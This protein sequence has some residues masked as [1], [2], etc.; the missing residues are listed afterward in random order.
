[1]NT[2]KSTKPAVKPARRYFHKLITR[3]VAGLGLVLIAM[4]LLLTLPVARAQTPVSVADANFLLAAAQGGLTEVAL[5]ELAAKKGTSDAV[6]DF[7]KLMI[8]DHGVINADLKT[9]AAQKGVTLP[10]RLD[11]QHQAMVD[12]LAALPGSEFDDT[13]V[14]EMIKAHQGDAKAFKDESAATQDAA[15]KGFVDKS[16]PVVEAHLK[17][18]A[19]MAK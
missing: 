11:E 7:G 13:Y 19:G 3:P 15:I 5:G 17:H 18:V 2:T 6:K 10:T 16:I 9:L 8:K 4:G 12:K 1:M 14:L